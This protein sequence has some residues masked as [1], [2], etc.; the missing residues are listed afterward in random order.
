LA[1]E[2]W[3][4]RLEEESRGQAEAGGASFMVGAVFHTIGIKVAGEDWAN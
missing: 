2:A 4:F 3:H 1:R